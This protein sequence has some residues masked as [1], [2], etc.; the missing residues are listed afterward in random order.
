MRQYGTYYELGPEQI[1]QCASNGP[2]GCDG[3][4]TSAATDY[5][6]SSGGI[7]LEV[8]YPFGPSAT[9]V[10]GACQPNKIDSKVSAYNSVSVAYNE[11]VDWAAVN[12]T[13]EMM[14]EHVLN[15]GTLSISLDA[16]NWNSYTGGILSKADCEAGCAR[17]DIPQN[18][19]CVDHA[20]QIVGVDTSET[21]GYWLVRNS[22]GDD[23]G[24]NGYIKIAYGQ[25]ACFITDSPMYINTAIPI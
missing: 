9:G 19:N 11:N 16:E 2:A 8:D 14:T 24:E 13:E 21:G 1:I 7:G 10:T 22:W 17:P 5:V 15:V 6:V 23:W 12:K 3:G 20:V 25:N 18:N 4:W